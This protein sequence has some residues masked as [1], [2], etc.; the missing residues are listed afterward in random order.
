VSKYK[1][2]KEPKKKINKDTDNYN[3]KTVIPVVVGAIAGNLIFPGVGGIVM[4]SL[5][6]G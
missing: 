5:I 2:L 1:Q 6:G 4:G 3:V